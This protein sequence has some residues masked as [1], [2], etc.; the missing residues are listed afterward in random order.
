MAECWLLQ[1]TK[2]PDALIHSVQE[3]L[4]V[5][6]TILEKKPS[7]TVPEIVSYQMSGWKGSHKML[8]LLVYT[9]QSCQMVQCL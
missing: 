6:G 9:F 5:S 3:P 1:Q 4:G 8:A 7:G 2:K